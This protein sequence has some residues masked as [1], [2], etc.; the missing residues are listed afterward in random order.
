MVIDPI[1]AYLG[2]GD[3]HLNADVRALALRDSFL[4]AGTYGGGIHRNNPSDTN[5]TQLNSGLTNTN[6]TSLAISGRRLYA[7]TTGGV[8][9]STND[10]A[11]WSA[12]STGLP[13]FSTIYAL[14]AV[15]SSIFASTNNGG[16]YVLRPSATTW[17]PAR[18][19]LPADANTYAFAR[20]GPTLY[21]GTFGSGVWR[22]PAVEMTSLGDEPSPPEVPS[23]VA[24]EQN[25]PNPFN[26]ET[27]IRFNVHSARWVR[28]AVYD[29][30]G[31]EVAVLAD[32]VVQPGSHEIRWDASALASGAYIYRLSAGEEIV[33]RRMMLVR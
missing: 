22:R 33:T 5:W 4:F 13:S 30:L 29:L 17:L 10:G 23:G 18:T 7:G 2:D 8:W 27:V 20:S 3:S 26:P 9:T 11:S 12:L 32:G 14:A 24:L 28:L 1:S 16:L 6:V 31:R 15:D 19:G 25:Y 21:A